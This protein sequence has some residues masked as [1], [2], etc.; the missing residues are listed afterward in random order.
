MLG[1]YLDNLSSNP[2]SNPSPNPSPN[3]SFG[4]RARVRAKA[5]VRAR[6]RARVTVDEQ[7]VGHQLEAAVVQ[8]DDHLGIRQS[9]NQAIR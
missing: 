3:P 6:V 1:S 4:V 7:Q 2:S 5:R 8:H 9:G